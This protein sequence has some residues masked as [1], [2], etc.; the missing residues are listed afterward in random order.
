M[1]ESPSQK[2]TSRATDQQAAA[3]ADARADAQADAPG[4]DAQ[5]AVWATTDAQADTQNA[6]NAPQNPTGFLPFLI[7]FGPLLVFFLVFKFSQD[8]ASSYGATAAA[9]RGTLA[10]MVAIIIAVAVSKWKLGKVSPMLWLSAILVIGF[11]GLT[12]YFHD[13][14]FIQIK[15]TIIYAAFAVLLLGGWARRKALLKYL[16]QAAYAGLDEV[17]WLTLS[18]NWGLFFAAMAFGNEVLRQI[19]DFEAWLTVKVWGVTA[20]SFL[21][22]MSQVPLMLRHGLALAVEPE[23]SPDE[24]EPENDADTE[25]LRDSDAPAR[26][27]GDTD[28]DTSGHKV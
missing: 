8:T 10:F 7:D 12:L 14:K 28:A 25:S 26:A 1:T 11:G 9:I 5:G 16:L 23:D 17:G 3:Q 19:L 6:P 2:Q 22:A 24:A 4:G 13:E 21:F 18:R 27:P 15:P 20:V